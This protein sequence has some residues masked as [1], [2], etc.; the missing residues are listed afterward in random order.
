MREISDQDRRNYSNDE[1][2]A[3]VVTE[4]LDRWSSAN[5]KF[6]EPI[7]NSKVR[8]KTKLKAVWDQANKV[9]AGRA[10]LEEKERFLNKLDRLLDILTCKCEIKS[11]ADVGCSSACVSE[12]HID[13]TCSKDAKIPVIELA[14]IKGQRE[15]VGSVG[16]H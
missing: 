1:L 2:I 11:C 9:S 4:L 6:I 16:P 15:K 10:R 14:F 13:C 8:I 5:P 12:A 3:D 7:I